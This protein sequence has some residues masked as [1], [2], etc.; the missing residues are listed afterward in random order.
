M[1][2][3][4]TQKGFSTDPFLYTKCQFSLYLKITDNINKLIYF[5]GEFVNKKI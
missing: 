2:F 4:V 3:F 5:I 1:S